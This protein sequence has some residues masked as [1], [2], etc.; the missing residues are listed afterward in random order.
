MAISGDTVFEFNVKFN[1]EKSKISL[2]IENGKLKS[3]K[4][5]NT[6]FDQDDEAVVKDSEILI[7]GSI[8]LLN[9]AIQ[10]ALANLHLPTIAGIELHNF[11]FNIKDKFVDFGVLPDI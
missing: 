11:D 6:T 2:F 5:T 7:S 4:T 8:S 10:T 9:I 1:I 3:F